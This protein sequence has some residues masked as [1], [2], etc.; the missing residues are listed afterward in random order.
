M[1]YRIRIYPN[2]GGVGGYGGM[3]MGMYGGA[4][5]PYAL[6][7]RIA[8]VK[9]QNERKTNN[10]RLQYERALWAEKLRTV[11]LQTAMQYSGY[12]AASPLAYGGVNAAMM[13]GMGS[14][15]PFGVLGGLGLGMF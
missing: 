5:G 14:F 1:A 4:Y 7:T 9:L 15:N 12:G 2:Y 10:L 11:Q 8:N 6:G 3:G 13:G